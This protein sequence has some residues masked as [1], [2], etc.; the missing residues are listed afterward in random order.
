MTQAKSGDTVKIHYTGRLND[1]T[2]FDSSAGRD[3]LEFTLGSGQ[4]IPG[5]DAGVDGMQVGESK[6]VEIPND[7][8]YGPHYAEMVATVGRDQLPEGMNPEIGDQLQVQQPNGQPVMV[9]VTASDDASITIDGNHPLAGKD[10]IFDIELV[11]IV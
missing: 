7:Q 4:V 11:E 3:P 9:V 5:F 8:A 2:V 1:G 10:L 6:T